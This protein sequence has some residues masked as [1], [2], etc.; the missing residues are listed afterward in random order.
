MQKIGHQALIS[1]DVDVLP[2]A[3]VTEEQDDLGH[4]LLSTPL[5]DDGTTLLMPVSAEPQPHQR[6]KKVT[7]QDVARALQ[8]A[9]GFVLANLWKVAILG[10][11]VALIF[12]VAIHGFS[13]F[14]RILLWVS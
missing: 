13:L 5:S 14:G 2:S 6:N 3:G 7:R 8:Q 4:H 11:I 1:E 12:L 9:L 10:L